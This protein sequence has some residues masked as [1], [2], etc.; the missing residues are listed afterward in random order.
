MDQQAYQ[1]T[2]AA[3][4]RKVEELYGG[5]I[6]VDLVRMSEG[7]FHYGRRARNHVAGQ[8]VRD[9]L[10]AKGDKVTYD[11]PQPTNWPDIQQRIANAERYLSDLEILTE[12]PRAS[13]EAIG[14]HAQEAL[15]NA[16]KGW[17]SALDADY[18][19]THDLAKLVAIVRQHPAENNTSAGERLAWLTEY[20]AVR[21]RYAG[22][23]V[24]M[25]DRFAL[26]ESVTETVAAII[27]RIRALV[28]TD[29]QNSSEDPNESAA[30]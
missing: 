29:S 3:A 20:A 22:A 2:S 30:E 27:A 9:G 6:D 15:E 25:D 18:R 13:Q 4:H 28:A 26:L 11:N 12:N 16:L 5:S 14:F 10:D 24:V 21:Y 23:E 1:R 17:I 7:A 8:A 19:N